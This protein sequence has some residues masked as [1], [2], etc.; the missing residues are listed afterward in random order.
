MTTDEILEKMLRE[1]AQLRPT[2]RESLNPHLEWDCDDAE[3]L[4]Q[5]LTGLRAALRRNPKE[6]GQVRV[7]QEGLVIFLWK[8]V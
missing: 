4:R 7:R 8:S 5:R 2:T 1:A 3:E 6:F